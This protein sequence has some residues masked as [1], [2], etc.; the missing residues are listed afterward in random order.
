MA[1]R[2]KSLVMSRVTERNARRTIG[3]EESH[4]FQPQVVGSADYNTLAG[5]RADDLSAG[6]GLARRGA[7]V[8]RSAG[9]SP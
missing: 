3:A 4:V 7:L 6:R 1:S 8:L 2:G 9:L 5:G